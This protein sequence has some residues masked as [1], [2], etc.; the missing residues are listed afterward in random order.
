[1]ELQPDVIRNLVLFKY[2]CKSS[3][4]LVVQLARQSAL[5]LQSI[6]ID[7]E[8]DI[9]FAG[10]VQDVDNS[11]VAYPRLIILKLWGPSHNNEPQRPAFNGTV[12]FSCLR[13]L[14]IGHDY[15]F[16]GDTFFR[17]N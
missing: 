12:P 14:S 10:L 11:Y 16:G 15:P 9:D 1:M 7:S 5:T 17:G 8:Q 13:S 6:D 3:V 4:S 2:T